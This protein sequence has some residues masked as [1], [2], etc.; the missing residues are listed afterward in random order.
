MQASS[1][2]N[3]RPQ[4][5]ALIWESEIVP[6]GDG[7]V[8][9]V[10]RKPLSEMSAKRAAR[11][12]GVSTW[13]VTDLYRLGL[14]QGRKPGARVL[15]RKDGKRSNAALMLDSESVLRYKQQRDEMS[16]LEA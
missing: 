14:I 5:L 16:R 15:K 10:A 1:T 6:R 13:T 4:Q 2:P 3:A 7:R 11:V 8:E 12:L 9:L